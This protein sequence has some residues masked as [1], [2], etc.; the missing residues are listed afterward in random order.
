VCAETRTEESAASKEQ[1]LRVGVVG[2]G[3]MGKPVATKILEAGYQLVVS[4]RDEQRQRDMAEIGAA[5]GTI[6]DVA[7]ADIVLLF[8]PGPREV[9]EVGGALMKRMHRGSVLI[10]LS[11]CAPATVQELALT[12]ADRA[13]SVVDAPVTGAADGAQAGALTLMVGAELGD[14]DAVRPVLEAFSERILHVGPVGSGTVV[15]LLTNM[16]WF[17]HI[18]ALCDALALGVR[19]GIDPSDLARIVPHTAGGSWA[20]VHDLPNIVCGHDDPSFTLALC[21]KD[22]GLISD[23]ARDLRVPI[24][25]TDVVST[26]FKQALEWF[27]DGAGELAVARV[28]EKTTGVSVRKNGRDGQADT[29]ANL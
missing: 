25:I 12:G 15:K 1:G 8:L 20:A 13:V 22:L 19:A 10:N 3:N 29:R 26:R 14:L 21:A 9:T 28:V 2:L 24:P 6:D 7:K 5:T 18:V 4:D 11:T 27:G 17:T 23:L 16:L